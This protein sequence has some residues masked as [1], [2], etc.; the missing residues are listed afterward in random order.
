MAVVAVP[1]RLRH[2]IISAVFLA[3][4][5]GLAGAYALTILSGTIPPQ[6]TDFITYFSAAR[7][8]VEG[9]GASL[10][11]FGALSAVERHVIAP[12][13]LTYGVLPYI[14]PPY[15]AA[16]IAPLGLGGLA[17][18]YGVWAALDV[19]WLGLALLVVQRRARLALQPTVILWLAAWTFVPTFIALLQG[20]VSFLLLIL[21]GGAL[22][23][24][25]RRLDVVA[26]ALLGAAMLK[27][28]YVLPCLVV[29]AVRG[30]W[31]SLLSFFGTS[32]LLAVLPMPLM[33][34]RVNVAYVETV[35]RAMGW[36]TQFGYGPDKTASLAG[37]LRD[38]LPSGAAFVALAVLTLAALAGL[39][40]L[41]RRS[42]DMA[43]PFALAVLVGLLISPH[44]LIHDLV[45]LLI[46]AAVALELRHGGPTWLPLALG[47]VY[48][49]AVV[50]LVLADSIHVQLI[51][52]AMCLLAAW[53]AAA[54]TS[55][56][57]SFRAA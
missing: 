18:A 17:A 55:P 51:I 42:S 52:L 53:L 54:I 28:T 30:R 33:G 12:Y 36:T 11:N 49:L 4:G 56:R 26:G 22:L 41:A 3:F 16:A 50:G 8:V 21:L 45:L 23:C 9:H 38:V 40:H 31:R 19:T 24:L 43:P 10:Y 1:G 15:F 13:R 35:R 46:P 27:P 29:L 5:I 34:I 25:E 37:P 7:M 32:A 2:R 6:K 57:E 14:Y 44:V 48:T 20:Q 47:S 39:S